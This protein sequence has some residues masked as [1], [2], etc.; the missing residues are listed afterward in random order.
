M[1]F[2]DICSF[3]HIHFRIFLFNVRIV[4]IGGR[5]EDG[6][7]PICPGTVEYMFVVVHD[8]G[9][10]L[11]SKDVAGQDDR[12]SPY[13]PDFHHPLLQRGGTTN[14][15]L[16]FIENFVCSPD[17][18]SWVKST[19]QAKPRHNICNSLSPYHHG[20]CL[21]LLR[22]VDVVPLFPYNMYIEHFTSARRHV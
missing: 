10:A 7:K 21:A 11:R 19:A 9:I 3:L 15:V 18:T 2:Q 4:H 17:C 14:I 13:P 16:C 1:A 5:Y 12:S 8:K 20:T 22:P 6:Q